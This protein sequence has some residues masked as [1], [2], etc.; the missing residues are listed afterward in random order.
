[1]LYPKQGGGLGKPSGVRGLGKI[2]LGVWGHLESQGQ[3]KGLVGGWRISILLPPW[4]GLLRCNGNR[5]GQERID[6][7]QDREETCRQL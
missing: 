1:M 4:E 2:L 3:D 5:E 6:G 7:Q